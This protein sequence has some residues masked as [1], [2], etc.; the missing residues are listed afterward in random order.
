MLLQTMKKHLTE[1]LVPRQ[2]TG[3]TLRKVGVKEG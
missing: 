2:V 3:W 1:Y